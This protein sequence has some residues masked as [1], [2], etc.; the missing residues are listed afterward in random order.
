MQGEALLLYVPFFNIFQI[1]GTQ[2]VDSCPNP[3]A[4]Q[5]GPKPKFFLYAL[6]ILIQNSNLVMFQVSF[7][8][9]MILHYSLY[10]FSY[11]MWFLSDVSNPKV[12]SGAEITV[13]TMTFHSFTQRWPQPLWV[14]QVV[15]H[16]QQRRLI[17][18]V[19]VFVYSLAKIMA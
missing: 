17:N 1:G 15:C 8:W 14:T 10:L 11:Q 13:I 2:Q 12:Q 5:F 18:L 19:T 9:C 4:I 6:Q 16:S 3:D 7:H